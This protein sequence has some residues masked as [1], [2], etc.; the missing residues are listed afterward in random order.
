M[1]R[2]DEAGVVPAAAVVVVAAGPSTTTTFVPEVE[3]PAYRTV[4]T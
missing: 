4:T 2:L 3:V 1:T